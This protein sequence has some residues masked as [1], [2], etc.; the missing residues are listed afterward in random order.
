MKSSDDSVLNI[1]TSS[2][3]IW[4]LK[5]F[6]DEAK[7]KY[8]HFSIDDKLGGG[9]ST[10]DS[11]YQSPSLKIRMIE[12]YESLG[13]TREKQNKLMKELE[14]SALEYQSHYNPFASVHDKQIMEH[15]YLDSNISS[16]SKT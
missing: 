7:S 3:R 6:L 5:N 9:S 11:R 16:G 15:Y 2:N 14:K 1:S 13:N 4:K 8:R 10:Y 12:T